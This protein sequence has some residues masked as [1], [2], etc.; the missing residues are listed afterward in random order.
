[1]NIEEKMFIIY[2]TQQENK[3]KYELGGRCPDKRDGLYSNNLLNYNFLWLM[4]RELSVGT[5]A[6][7]NWENTHSAS[8]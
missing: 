5:F 7:Q 1:M 4:L 3:N 2:N 8:E 6:L